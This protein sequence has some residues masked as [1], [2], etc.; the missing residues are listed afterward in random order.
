MLHAN[1]D[2][3]LFVQI[4][5]ICSGTLQFVEIGDATSSFVLSIQ[6]IMQ[7]IQI[8]DFKLNREIGT[9]NVFLFL[10]LKYFFMS[11]MKER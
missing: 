11:N 4:G 3:F 6:R 8:K 7:N 5:N 10:F 1:H 9:K 2:V